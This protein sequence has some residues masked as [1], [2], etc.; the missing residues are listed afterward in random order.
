MENFERNFLIDYILGR[1]SPEDSERVE[2]EVRVNSEL[3]QTLETLRDEVTFVENSRVFSNRRRSFFSPLF[4]GKKSSFKNAADV[5]AEPILDVS[6]PK[7]DASEDV[8]LSSAR[9]SSVSHETVFNEQENKSPRRR[10]KRLEYIPKLVE[11]PRRYERSG[12]VFKR[13]SE[14]AANSSGFRRDSIRRDRDRAFRESIFTHVRDGVKPVWAILD[15]DLFAVVRSRLPQTFFEVRS[16]DVFFSDDCVFCSDPCKYPRNFLKSSGESFADEKQDVYVVVETSERVSNVFLSRIESDQEIVDITQAGGK[17]SSVQTSVSSSSVVANLV[18][19]VE[20]GIPDTESE[21]LADI[22]REG[23]V[24]AKFVAETP[25]PA[26]IYAPVLHAE[27]DG[28]GNV[29]EV[30]SGSLAEDAEK[31]T[32]ETLIATNVES[33]D[34]LRQAE[35]VGAGTDI[36]A[37]T[38]DKVQDDFSP[39]Q[40]SGPATEIASLPIVFECSEDPA[41]SES[42]RVTASVS[43]S[44][45]DKESVDDPVSLESFRQESSLPIVLDVR[46]IDA[47]STPFV[48]TSIEP[49]GASALV[50]SVRN[51]SDNFGSSTIVSNDLGAFGF[52][53][54]QSV[55]SSTLIPL[56]LEPI[57]EVSSTKHVQ[58]VAGVFDSKFIESVTSSWLGSGR[59]ETIDAFVSVAPVITDNSSFVKPTQI[60]TSD[61]NVYDSKP[62]ESLDPVAFGLE[63][64]EDVDS[65]SLVSTPA[66]PAEVPM[67]IE[68]AQLVS[69]DRGAADF[70][71]N[72]P[73]DSFAAEL[74][75]ELLRPLPIVAIPQTDDLSTSEPI[76]TTNTTA[77]AQIC[78]LPECT[79][80]LLDVQETLAASADE[81]GLGQDE[82]EV[83]ERTFNQSEAVETS[84]PYEAP[85]QAVTPIAS[86]PDRSETASLVSRH[87]DLNYSVEPDEEDREFGPTLKTEEQFLAELLGRTPT[88]I[89]LDEYYWEDVDDSLESGSERN[90]VSK[91]L[92]NVVMVA[93]APPVWVGRVTIDAFCTCLPRRSFSGE[94]SKTTRRRE[95]KSRLSDMMIS[96]VAGVMIAVCF[97]FPALRY[98]VREIYTTVAASKVRKISENVSL[99]P[100][101]TAVE[102]SLLPVLSKHILYPRY[103]PDGAHTTE[104]NDGTDNSLFDLDEFPY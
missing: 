62:V 23:D 31:A 20:T 49:F 10:I 28:I 16:D 73:I 74:E 39:V 86:A 2:Q 30:C 84:V 92:Y 93:T 32:C 72:E 11:A 57:D 36:A 42:T 21:K 5:E 94:D 33:D 77:F 65:S 48:S 38:F 87:S 17:L 3:A 59:T 91:F 85:I 97:V 50:E 101:E 27:K 15:V 40:A 29:E 58:S 98:V 25:T 60:D 103:N 47:V 68:S 1:L 81:V 96:T 89:E 6:G 100:Q 22:V 104:E 51:V 18:S 35:E 55:D 88:A 76:E 82:T 54:A 41:I 24:C 13:A 66:E 64:V 14:H 8:S 95:N 69:S 4:R 67:L 9:P 37:Q 71:P 102:E 80:E 83:S 12:F 99:S 79:S 61:S 19:D 34:V 43:N 56:P 52:T 7:V 26:E 78:A 53:K 46:Q 75:Q 44:F 90:V 63:E 45:D 70:I